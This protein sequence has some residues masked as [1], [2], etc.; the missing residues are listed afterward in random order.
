MEVQEELELKLD[1][2]IK[3]PVGCEYGALIGTFIEAYLRPKIEKYLE[4]RE[5]DKEEFRRIGWALG[6]H[7]QECTKAVIKACY[8]CGIP[9][10]P[11]KFGEAMTL[12]RHL[13]YHVS[14]KGIWSPDRKLFPFMKGPL[15]ENSLELN[16]L[17]DLILLDDDY[18]G[19]REYIDKPLEYTRKGLVEVITDV[20]HIYKY[21]YELSKEINEKPKIDKFKKFI[22]I[23]K[24]KDG[25]NHSIIYTKLDSKKYYS[26]R[27]AY[28]GEM[29]INRYLEEKEETLDNLRL[30]LEIECVARDIPAFE[31]MEKDLSNFFYTQ[32]DGSLPIH[33]REITTFPINYKDLIADGGVL[34]ALFTY[35]TA[36]RATSF[37]INECGLHFHVSRE[38]I[39]KKCDLNLVYERIIRFYYG[40]GESKGLN[41]RIFLRG[42]G[43][44]CRKT[45]LINLIE[46]I[47]FE[48]VKNKAIAKVIA[49]E[50]PQQHYFEICFHENG[51]T[52]EFRR[53]KGCISPEHVKCMCEYVAL[54]V[55]YSCSRLSTGKNDLDSF[56]KFC[57]K[58]AKT[59]RLRNILEL[60]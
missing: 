49:Q 8:L 10:P 40:D 28:H 25:N 39:E 55:R 56:K 41:N 7:Q 26:K 30:G 31:V 4:L 34:D 32:R 9:L 6:R 24:S 29:Q 23:K 33:G 13:A 38:V 20:Y 60:D 21:Y 47:G 35:H 48:N 54:L 22:K 16:T 2:Q 11:M 43:H 3:A 1:D 42:N 58:R 36:H 53:G 17:K 45:T 51:I 19:D 14:S 12:T 5:S 15:E 37:D 50:R 57:A 46:R 27:R 18:I 44:Y 59:R 52:L